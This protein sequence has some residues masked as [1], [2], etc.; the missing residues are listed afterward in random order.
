MGEIFR[1]VEMEP[2]MIPLGSLL[3]LVVVMTVSSKAPGQRYTY[4]RLCT[5][6]K[7]NSSQEQ[8]LRSRLK[9]APHSHLNCADSATFRRLGLGGSRQRPRLGKEVSQLEDAGPPVSPVDVEASP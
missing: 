3:L 5:S 9:P 6:A 2:P 4:C 1:I 8:G 7:H